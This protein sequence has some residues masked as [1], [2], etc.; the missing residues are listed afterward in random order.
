MWAARISGAI[1]AMSGREFGAEMG[2]DD[3]AEE[4]EAEEEVEV[5]VN[6]EDSMASTVS[7]R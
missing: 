3:E 7:G 4:E 1:S 6:E 2:L 5:V